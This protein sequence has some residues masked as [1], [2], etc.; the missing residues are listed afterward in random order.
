V[1]AVAYTTTTRARGGL[2]D[3]DAC[4]RRQAGCWAL[5]GQHV[6][7]SGLPGAFSVARDGKRAAGRFLGGTRRHAG[8]RSHF[9][10]GTWRQAGCQAHSRRHA[11]ASGL[12]GAFSAVLAQV[13]GLARGGKWAA[14][15]FLGGTRWQTGCRVLSR[16]HVA[17]SGL[18]DAFS[19]AR[20][21]K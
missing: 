10:G 19:A 15:R 3:D 7:T 20:G 17:A 18:S 5:P 8:Y 13:I 21:G 11:T 2:H 1:H 12:P 6:A 16:Q 9:L 4:T 14:R